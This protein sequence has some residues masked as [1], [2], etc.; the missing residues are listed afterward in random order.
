M[1]IEHKVTK[2]WHLEA[3][4]REARGIVNLIRR[5][6]VRD[7]EGRTYGS[8]RPGGVLTEALPDTT[9]ASEHK[10]VL[11]FEDEA[12]EHRVVFTHADRSVIED[13][14]KLL[15]GVLDAE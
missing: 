10:L 13:L 7:D 8:N 15:K 11:A 4:Y 2:P 12:W 6:Y 3:A 9:L 1:V 14:Y 5:Y